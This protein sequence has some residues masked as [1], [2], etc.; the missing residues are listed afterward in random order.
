MAIL[1]KATYRFYA[2]ESPT[3]LFTDM[4]KTILNTI[5]KN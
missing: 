5:W 4:E 3:N 1:P 2:M